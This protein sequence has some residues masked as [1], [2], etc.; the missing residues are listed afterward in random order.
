MDL[1]H[2]LLA[3]AEAAQEIHSSAPEAA[4]AATEAATHAEES[5][6][7]V[8]GTLGINWMLFVAQLVNFSVVLLVFWKWVVKPLGKTL[9]DRQEKIES[10]LK[11]AD[12]MKEEKQKFEAWKSEEM[13]KVRT[14]ADKILKTSGE[15]AEKIRAETISAAQ[16]Q[17]EKMIEQAKS[18]I[19]AEKG[20]MLK[21]VKSEVATL[22]VMASEKIL[23]SK[24]DP[25]KDHELVEE[26]VKGIK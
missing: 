16:Q 21:E 13:N 15:A 14:E 22:V 4:Q 8:I 23:K 3:L 6:G 9:S 10:G 18:A 11:N 25:K 19:E 24:L 1:H 2:A 17:A 20:Q 26:S 12:Y 5:S 7:G